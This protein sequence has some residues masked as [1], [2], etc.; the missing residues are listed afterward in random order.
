MQLF[1]NAPTKIQSLSS[2]R[3]RQLRRTCANLQWRRP[4]K[5]SVMPMA[6]MRL[7][8]WD[9]RPAAPVACHVPNRVRRMAPPAASAGLRATRTSL[10]SHA[11]TPISAWTALLPSSVGRASVPFA[12]RASPAHNASTLHELCVNGSCRVY[13][14]PRGGGFCV[15]KAVMC[16]GKNPHF[17]Q[18]DHN[19]SQK[20]NFFVSLPTRE[21]VLMRPTSAG[22]GRIVREDSSKNQLNS[23]G[24]GRPCPKMEKVEV[25]A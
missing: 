24:R 18:S 12:A 21:K 6:R 16:K 9:R 7:R 10:C 5:S 25:L 13:I 3:R 17:Y 11:G 1:L 23:R 15:V 8:T 2:I 20:E 4:K 14:S 22:M 19:L